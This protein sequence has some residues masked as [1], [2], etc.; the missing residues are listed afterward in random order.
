MKRASQPE[1]TI[2]IPAYREAKRIGKTLDELAIYLKKEL[3]FKDMPVEVIVVSAD[4]L[5]ETQEIVKSRYKKFADI[6]LLEPGLKVGKGRDVQYGML[7]AKGK[8]VVFMDADLATPLR[9]LP[10]FYKT[11]RKGADLVVGTRNLHKHHPNI[12]RRMI[13]TCGNLLFKLAGGV[14]IEDSQCGFKMFSHDAAQLCFSK[15]SI[16]GWGFDMEILAIAKANKLNI[17]TF[18]VNDWISVP[19]GT[20]TEGVV[21]NVLNSLKELAQIFAKRLTGVYKVK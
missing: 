7:Q 1:L 21:K 10:K 18:R 14:W 2:V 9:H 6:K 4:S 16:M 5:D 15:L 11:Q 20:F 17:V 8:T 19:E 13:S 12:L 3:V